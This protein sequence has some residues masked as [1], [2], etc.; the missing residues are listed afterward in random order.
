[1]NKTLIQV[2]LLWAAFS[3]PAARA[4]TVVE[5]DLASAKQLLSNHGMQGATK[6]LTSLANNYKQYTNIRVHSRNQQEALATLARALRTDFDGSGTSYISDLTIWAVLN[7]IGGRTYLAA[8]QMDP[9]AVLLTTDLDYLKGMLAFEILA[10]LRDGDISLAE[11]RRKAL[12]VGIEM[13]VDERDD[14]ERTVT[15]FGHH[16]GEDQMVGK[17]MVIEP[18]DFVW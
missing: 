1:M 2:A 12:K 9:S 7:D 4:Q 14:G 5:M 6:L 17:L 8:S 10:G 11:A 18:P 16:P 3:A 13:Q 15:F